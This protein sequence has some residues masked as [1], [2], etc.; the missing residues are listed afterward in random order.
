MIKYLREQNNYSQNSIATFLGISRQMYIKYENGD[1]EPPLKVVVELAKFYRVP[2]EVIIDGKI[3]LESDKRKDSYSSKAE[4]G[5]LSLGEP[6]P[7]YSAE[8]DAKSTASYYFTAIMEMLPKLVYTEQLK[9]LS[10]IST[11][12]QKETE[13]KIIPN[14]KMQAFQRILALNEELHLKSDG[15]K[16]TREEIYER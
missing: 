3:S 13:E 4:D 10:K 6:V 9:L 14:K 5:A 15:K 8:H 1:V 12:V 11:M 2:Y 16:W 7:E